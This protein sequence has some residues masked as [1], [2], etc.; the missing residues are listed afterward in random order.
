MSLRTRVRELERRL[1]VPDPDQVP[2]VCIVW[3]NSKAPALN[4][5]PIRWGTI[6]GV[7]MVFER[8]PDESKDDFLARLMALRPAPRGR[9]DTE[10]ITIHAEK[11]KPESPE[12]AS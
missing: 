9:F 5:G 10:G 7:P 12:T 1:A 4:P 6:P 3:V 2:H 11:L 8:S